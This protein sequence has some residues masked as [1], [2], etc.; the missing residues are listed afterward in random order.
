MAYGTALRRLSGLLATVD[1]TAALARLE[2]LQGNF[3]LA[4]EN[5]SVSP[6]CNRP[7]GVTNLHLV[8]NEPAAPSRCAIWQPPQF[9]CRLFTSAAAWSKL[10]AEASLAIVA[11]AVWAFLG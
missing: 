9:A 4:E 10:P 1:T 6:G 5:F 2:P 8:L 11:A 3:D 7:A